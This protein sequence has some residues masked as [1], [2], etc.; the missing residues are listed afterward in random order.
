LGRLSACGPAL[1][2]GVRLGCWSWG[3]ELGPIGFVLRVASNREN[4][5]RDTLLRKIEIEGLKHL[6][7]RILVPTEKTKT[8]TGGK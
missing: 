5:V 2:G 8:L 3:C 1:L 4:H 7:D 6:V